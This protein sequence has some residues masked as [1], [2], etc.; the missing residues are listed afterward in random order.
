MYSVFLENYSA[1]HNNNPWKGWLWT[2]QKFTFLDVFVCFDNS[3]SNCETGLDHL[4][5]RTYLFSSIFEIKSNDTYF[6]NKKI[7]KDF[8]FSKEYPF[9]ILIYIKVKIYGNLNKIHTTFQVKQNQQSPQYI[10]NGT[11]ILYI[12]ESS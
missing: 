8:L 9:C 4:K 6:R 1:E 11:P 10:Y 5:F 3:S 2:N 12:K 7:L